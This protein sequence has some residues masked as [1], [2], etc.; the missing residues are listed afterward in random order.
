MAITIVAI[1]AIA[2]VLSYLYTRPTNTGTTYHVVDDMGYFPVGAN[3]YTTETFQINGAEWSIRWADWQGPVTT[4]STL[5][6]V[7]HD[8]YTNAIIKTVSLTTSHT[9]DYLNTKGRFYLVVNTN[10]VG[11]TVNIEIWE[12]QP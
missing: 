12:S 2:I 3:G 5:S 11:M 6:I 7:V 9:V 10:T 8:G 4:S 1:V